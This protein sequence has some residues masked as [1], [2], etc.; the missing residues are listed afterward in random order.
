MRGIDAGLSAR[1]LGTLLAVANAP[2]LAQST[3]ATTAQ[4]VQSG[5]AAGRD[6]QHDFDFEFGKWRVHHR[7]KRDGHWADF[8]GTC[9]D[10]GLVDGSANVEEHTFFRKAGTGYGTRPLRPFAPGRLVCVMKS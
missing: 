9:T 3:P 5:T 6:G 8:E 1:V 7:V 4:A 10:R 2:V